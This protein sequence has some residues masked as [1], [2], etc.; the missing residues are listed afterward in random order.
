MIND[1]LKVYFNKPKTT[2]HFKTYCTIGKKGQPNDCPF[3]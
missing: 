1:A 2:S 3:K